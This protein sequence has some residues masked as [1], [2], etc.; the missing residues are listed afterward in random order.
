MFARLPAFLLAFVVF[1]SCLVTPEDAAAGPAHPGGQEVATTLVAGACPAEAADDLVD[2]H[3]MHE[4]RV[5]ANV[6]PPA[7]N[8]DPLHASL[9]AQVPAAMMDPPKVLV[10]AALRPLYL[11]TP[12]RPPCVASIAA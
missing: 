4:Q 12:Q 8:S 7:D 11:D 10:M 5:P 9:A 3:P 1:W 2:E 6:E